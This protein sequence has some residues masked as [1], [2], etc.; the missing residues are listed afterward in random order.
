MNS[1]TMG[2]LLLPTVLVL[3]TFGV[4]SAQADA[5]FQ[6]ENLSSNLASVETS[7]NLVL[8]TYREDVFRADVKDAN[9]EMNYVIS[10]FGKNSGPD[11]FADRSI[12][13]RNRVTLPGGEVV[14]V[15]EPASM[16]LLASGLVGGAGYLR[17]RYRVTK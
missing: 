8:D 17:K 14:V 13:D 7:R 15:P 10:S 11:L 3:L 9:V 12:R 5:V 1:R 6:V 16:L 4:T 2:R